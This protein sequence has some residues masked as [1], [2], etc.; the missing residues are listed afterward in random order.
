MAKSKNNVITHGLSGLIGDLLVFRQRANKTIVADRPRPFSKPATAVQL[1]IQARFKKAAQYAKT[2]IL[3]PLIKAAYQAA[4][5]LGQSA[6]N[7]AFKDYQLAPEFDEEL[8][9][10]TYTGNSNEEIS[11]SVIDDFQV[12]GV[13]VQILKPDSS[14]LEEGEAVQSPNGLDWIY[15]TTA[16]IADVIG[17]RIIFTASD[18]PGNKTVL[19][20]VML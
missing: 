7:R 4:A 15:T 20:K 18:V 14:L 19:E 9:L 6:F 1:G 11:V 13:H 3:D 8:D 2:A 5:L 10:S 12:M 16:V 17:C